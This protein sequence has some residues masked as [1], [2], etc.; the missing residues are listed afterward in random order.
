M[1]AQPN[2]VKGILYPFQQED[3][4]E[5]KEVPSVLLA[6]EMGTG[7]TFAGVELDLQHRVD[8]SGLTLVVA[9]LSVLPTWEDH[10]N[11]LAPHLTTTVVDPKARARFVA[12][13]KARKHDVYI[14]H[15]EVLR[16]IPELREIHWLHIIADEVHRIKNRKAQQTRALKALKT[17]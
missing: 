7:K 13:L 17:E 16:L 14:C 1:T 11:S 9:P 6:W 8:A 15:W 3:T 12:D 5:L 10:F 2:L 4:S